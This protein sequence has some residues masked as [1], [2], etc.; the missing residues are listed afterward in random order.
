[1]AVIEGLDLDDSDPP[2]ELEIAKKFGWED[3]YQNGS[4]TRWQ[5]FKPRLWSIFDEPWSSRCARVYK[6]LLFFFGVWM[7]FFI[8]FLTPKML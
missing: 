3:A 6:F 1:M 8:I 4:M 2:T 7:A 5:H